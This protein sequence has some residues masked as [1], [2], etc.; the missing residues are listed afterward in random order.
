MYMQ[1]KF[2]NARG[3]VYMIGLAVLVILLAWKFI[4]G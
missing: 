1:G 3:I 2:N 4:V